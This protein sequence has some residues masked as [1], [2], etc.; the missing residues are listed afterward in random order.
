MILSLGGYKIFL[1]VNSKPSHNIFL[2]NEILKGGLPTKKSFGS[3]GYKIDIT[4]ILINIC[5][6]ITQPTANCLK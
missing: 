3:V 2:T 5:I 6:P 4:N 1:E